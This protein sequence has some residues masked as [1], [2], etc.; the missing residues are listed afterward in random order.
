MTNRQSCPA[1]YVSPEKWEKEF[2]S[3]K[4]GDFTI[5]ISKAGRFLYG[6]L[7]SGDHCMCDLAPECPD[8]WTFNED[9]ERPTLHPSV[10]LRK[11]GPGGLLEIW[12]GWLREGEWKSC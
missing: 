6:V 10:R 7:P 8:G 3:L 5:Q 2:R 9:L 12:H 11:P 1:R 4:P